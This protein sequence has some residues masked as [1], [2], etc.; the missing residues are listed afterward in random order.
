MRGKLFNPA[1]TVNV[2]YAVRKG[3]SP[4]GKGWQLLG[5][6]VQGTSS[7]GVSAIDTI[8][9]FPFVVPS[10]RRIAELLSEVTVAAVGGVMRAAI[11]NDNGGN[12]VIGYPSTLVS[13]FG[14]KSTAVAA[15]LV[16]GGLSV[17]LYGG[18]Y[19]W[20]A[21]TYGVATPTVR[22]VTNFQTICGVNSTIS[23]NRGISVALAYAAFPSTFPSGAAFSTSDSAR[24]AFA[25]H[26]DQ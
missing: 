11:Y 14:E 5:A 18:K 3:T 4:P 17:K 9:A 7:A 19:Y 8:Y 20:F 10:S 15:V 2:D 16:W 13:D 23:N 6:T 26:Y 24:P 12:G 22:I 25:A 21:V 1:R